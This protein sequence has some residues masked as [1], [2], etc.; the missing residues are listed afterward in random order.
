M[1]YILEEIYI[2]R[3]KRFVCNKAFFLLKERERT[4]N[5][6]LKEEREVKKHIPKTMRYTPTNKLIS[7]HI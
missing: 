4:K 3:K 2:G 1:R 7:Y 6:R 5:G